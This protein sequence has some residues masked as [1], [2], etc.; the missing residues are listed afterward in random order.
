M[1]PLRYTASPPTGG[2]LQPHPRNNKNKN[3]CFLGSPDCRADPA[4]PFAIEPLWAL[5][6]GVA[7]GRRAADGVLKVRPHGQGGL[8]AAL[9][10]AAAALELEWGL[11]DWTP[12][13]GSP[14]V[15]TSS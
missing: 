14:Q 11:L 13:P 9:R 6:R 1:W 7:E 15:A 5:A 12:R 3:T 10:R 8:V 2:P 4:A